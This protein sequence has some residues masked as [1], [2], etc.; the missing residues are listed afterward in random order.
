[1][2]SQAR[3]V[4]FLSA[5]I[6]CSMPR[7]VKSRKKEF[8]VPRGRKPSAARPPVSVWGKRPFTI[9]YEVPSPPTARKLRKPRSRAL[10]ASI[11]ASPGRL[12]TTTSRSMSNCRTRSSAAPASL[13]QRPPPAAGLTTAKKRCFTAEKPQQMRTAQISYGHHPL[14]AEALPDFVGQ[15]AALDFERRGQ[16]KVAVPD[17]IAADALVIQ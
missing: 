3:R 7:E 4:P 2:T 10:R 6:V 17:E 13:P 15:F 9:S 16:R 8:P 5:S 11:V 12:V 1:M 14:A